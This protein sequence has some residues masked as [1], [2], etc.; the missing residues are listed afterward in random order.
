[1]VGGNFGRIYAL[2]RNLF[3]LRRCRAHLG[4]P[5]CVQTDSVIGFQQ[6]SVAISPASLDQIVV[7]ND[8]GV[9]VHGWRTFLSGLN[10]LFRTSP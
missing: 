4:K 9:A 2:G 8:F 7:A 1:M 10:Q 6:H 5:L 3:P